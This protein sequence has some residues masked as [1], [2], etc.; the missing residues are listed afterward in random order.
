[1]IKFIIIAIIFVIYSI[2]IFLFGR[3]FGI[4]EGHEMTRNLIL[5]NMMLKNDL[6]LK[7]IENDEFQSHVDW[8]NRFNSEEH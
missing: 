5:E 7:N 2:T 4:E 8:I 3:G 1:M 6:S